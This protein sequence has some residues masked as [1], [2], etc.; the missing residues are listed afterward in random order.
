[1]R[2]PPTSIADELRARPTSFLVGKHTVVVA[3]LVPAWR[4]SVTVDGR[5]LGATFETQASAWE[6]GVQ[7]ADRADR[8]AG[9]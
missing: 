6:A 7:D 9:G 8:E 2:H 3:Q 4:W 1:M 5:L